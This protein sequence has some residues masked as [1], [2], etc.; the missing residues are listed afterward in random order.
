VSAEVL[1]TGAAGHVG[2]AVARRLVAQGR[3]VIGVVRPGGRCD[4]PGARVVELDLAD[5][6]AVARV[7]AELR[8][9]HVIHTAV[10]RR[11]AAS[12]PR[13]PGAQLALVRGLLRGAR[14]HV[15]A[16]FIHSATQME[17]PRLARAL[18]ES[19]VAAVPPTPFGVA[20]AAAAAACLEAA[21]A[22]LPVVI[23]RPFTVYGP[24][25]A[26]ERLV[27][28]AF[29]AALTGKPLPLTRAGLRRDY[30]YIEDVA[31]AYVTALDA[32]LAPGEA[33]NVAS[34]VQT[35]N[36]ELVALVEE[37]TGR[38]IDVRHGAYAPHV[39]DSEHWVADVSKAER[40]LGFRARI[41]LREGLVRTAAHMRERVC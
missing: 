28:S 6:I 39:T 26:A 17:Y 13:Y 27:P 36:E 33:L 11:L 20:K 14:A 35:A 31:D 2:A 1:I 30:I 15:P 12:D 4:V 32:P 37:V 41:P 7:Y 25:E 34:G 5:E 8:P 38:R 18:R 24:G 9:S 10:E 29:V 23:L 3:A 22:G 19:D 40:L 21:R 16:C